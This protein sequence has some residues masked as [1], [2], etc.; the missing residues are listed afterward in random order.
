MDNASFGRLY[1]SADLSRK[2]RDLAKQWACGVVGV[3][4]IEQEGWLAVSQMPAGQSTETYYLS[5]VCAMEKA[6]KREERYQN[7]IVD[8]AIA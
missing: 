4:D 8:G 3:D 2:I 6:H 7:Q 1:R 5:A